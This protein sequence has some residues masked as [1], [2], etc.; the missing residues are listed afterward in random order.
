MKKIRYKNSFLVAFSSCLVILLMIF[1]LSLNTRGTRAHFNGVTGTL[2]PK[3]WVTYSSNWPDTTVENEIVESKEKRD[4][5]VLD[6]MFVV[7]VGYEF[8]GWN[9]LADGTGDMYLGNNS[10]TLTNALYLYA[11]WTAVI[12]DEETDDMDTIMYGDVN[13]DGQIDDNDYMLIEN[14]ISGI[15]N[16]MEQALLNADVNTDGNIDAIDVDIIKQAYLGTEGYNGYL[17]NKFVPIY[18][19]YN[20]SNSGNE[21]E[22]DGNSQGDNSS[23]GTEGTSGNSSSSDSSNGGGNTTSGNGTGTTGS[24]NNSSANNG[25]NNYS[26]NPSQ[27]NIEGSDKV[28]RPKITYEFRYMVDELE[29]D[30]ITCDATTDL[31]CELILP[32]NNPVMKGYE[33]SGWSLNKKCDTDDKII[34]PVIVNSSHT[35]YACFVEIADENIENNKKSYVWVVVIFLF[36]VAFRLIWY[37]V[38][39]FRKEQEKDL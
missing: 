27:E 24:T 1:Y 12:S 18:E 20:G 31:T 37:F 9:T 3:Y 34:A 30:L 16:L 7:P 28:E 23:L 39:R 13:Q 10:I 33:F 2:T 14:Y 25:N 17:P 32:E 29:Y 11:Q 5:V 36:V 38:N 19:V 22:E 35:Y 8:S 15:N 21:G 4:Y 26:N 6:N